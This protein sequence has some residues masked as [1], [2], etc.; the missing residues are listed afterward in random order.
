MTKAEF[1]KVFRL[2]DDNTISL[3]VDITALFGCGKKTYT[4]TTVTIE[5]AAAGL[6]YQ[7]KQ[8]NDTWD[9]DELAAM[10]KIYARKIQ[11][12]N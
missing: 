5:A 7:A 10:A 1:K 4:K 12:A 6:R 3:D 2:A 9:S 8:L 11:L